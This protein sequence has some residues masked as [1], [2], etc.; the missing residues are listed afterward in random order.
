MIFYR[1]VCAA[2]LDLAPDQAIEAIDTIVCNSQM[3]GAGMPDFRRW[4]PGASSVSARTTT[5]A[6]ASSI[7]HALPLT[8]GPAISIYP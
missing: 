1:S 8:R 7:T 3:P 5:A 4:C 6:A 2:A